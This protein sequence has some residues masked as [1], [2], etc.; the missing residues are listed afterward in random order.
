MNTHLKWTAQEKLITLFVLKNKSL[1]T[2]VLR[3]AGT[4]TPAKGIWEFLEAIWGGLQEAIGIQQAQS[5]AKGQDGP[6][7]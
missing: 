2:V 6:I 3:Q 5:L 4:P 7:H 1:K